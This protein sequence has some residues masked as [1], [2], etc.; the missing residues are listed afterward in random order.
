MAFNRKIDAAISLADLYFSQKRFEEGR[1]LIIPLLTQHPTEG[2]LY[3]A[4][5]R[6]YFAV[7]QIHDAELA[8][9][10]A[11]S[12]SHKSADVHLLLAK[13]YE[14]QHNRAALITQLKAYLDESGSGP[15]ADAVRKQLRDLTGEP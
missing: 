3:A 2:D 8:G 11:Q 5:A 4:L 6:N 1:N 9:L 10:N 15:T 14:G 12:R 7:G 13:I